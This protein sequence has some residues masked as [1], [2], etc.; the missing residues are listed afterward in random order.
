MN[1]K[2]TR[3]R[4]PPREREYVN[5][6]VEQATLLDII[7]ETR[8]TSVKNEA[9]RQLEEVGYGLEVMEFDRMIECDLWK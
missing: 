3:R 5:L 1:H 7:E 8:F 9:R 2:E 6:K 4:I